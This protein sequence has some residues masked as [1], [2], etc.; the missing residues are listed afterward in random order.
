MPASFFGSDPGLLLILYDAWCFDPDA[1]RGLA[2]AVWS[3]VH[4]QPMSGGDKVF[5]A[6]SYAQPI[7]MSRY[8]EQE[9]RKLGLQPVYVP[10][11]VDTNVFRP[12]DDGERAAA[13]V[14]LGVPKD[15]FMVAMVGANK[16]S[17]PPRKGWG[18]AFQ[19]FARHLKKH[20]DSYLYVPYA[21][22]IPAW[23]RP[24][25]YRRVSGY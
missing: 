1:I 25:S 4:S 23:H 3:P 19:A 5:Y 11:G 12:L 7:A 9:M 20:P 24:S 8:G 16:G 13:R 18:E 15:A 22:R 2:T 6:R 14:A 21:R 10:H 17:S